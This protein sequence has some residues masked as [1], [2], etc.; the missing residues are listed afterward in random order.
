MICTDYSYTTHD[1][2]IGALS[3]CTSNGVNCI[4]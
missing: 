3:T 4:T 2:C 1:K